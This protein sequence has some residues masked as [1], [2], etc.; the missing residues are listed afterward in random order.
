MN[1]L[2][3]NLPLLGKLA[4]PLVTLLLVIVLTV[5][6]GLSGI[7]QLNDSTS[8]ALGVVARRQAL[9]LAV[10]AQ[11]NDAVVFEKN[12]IVETKND[13]MQGFLR[14]YEAAMKEARSKAEELVGLASDPA[15]RRVLESL[16][17]A[18]AGLEEATRRSVALGLKNETEAAAK[19]SLEQVRPARLKVSEIAAEVVGYNAAQMQE[20]IRSTGEL[21]ATVDRNLKLVSALG[22]AGGFALLAWIVLGY[23]VRPLRRMA[24]AMETIARGDLTLQVEG[25]GRKDEVGTLARSLQV[26]K[27]N[28]LEMR[29]LQAEQEALKEKAEADRKKALRQLADSFEASVKGVVETVASA[30]TEMQ[31][32]AASMSGTAEEASRQ[33]M[34]VASAAEQASANVQTVA[35]AT[36]E[37]TAS[38]QEI[39]RQVATSTQVAGQAVLETRRTAESIGGLVAAAK[40][41]GAVV[42]M[43]QSIAGQTNL[44]ALNATIEAARAGDAGKGFAVVAS[45]VKALAN[46]TAK[47]TEEIQAKVQ[48]IQQATGGAEAAV[49]GIEG[50]IG[51]MN[52]IAGAIAAAVEQQSAATR[53]ISDNVQQAARGTEEVSSNISGVNQAAAETGSAATQ[54]LG[55]AG[56]LSKEA[57]T[58]R[59]EV[60]SFIATVRAA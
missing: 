5:W 16:R 1:R 57:E 23:V 4:V 29:R 7:G 42:D 43:I 55:T 40:Q 18:L 44:L 35:T 27:E 50:T 46:Q 60:T 21:A 13:A 20:T 33:A 3:S 34:A 19:I 45:E 48:E 58:L 47:A 14:S 54:V 38:I 6:Q 10:T 30:A 22:F 32:A 2:L 41:I 37:L 56:A 17:D 25:T 39:G 31:S 11:A 24:G 36:E 53:D 59:R 12:I 51:R 28:G 52:E 9:A 8:H 15:R 49:E 26:F